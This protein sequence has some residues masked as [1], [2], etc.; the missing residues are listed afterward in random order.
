MWRPDTIMQLTLMV[1]CVRLFVVMPFVSFSRAPQGEPSVV[2]EQKQ[3]LVRELNSA[4]VA[5]NLVMGLITRTSA[6][7]LP[8]LRRPHL[9]H[10]AVLAVHR[11][12]V[13]QHL[14]APLVEAP[15]VLRGEVLEGQRELEVLQ[16]QVGLPAQELPPRVPL[17]RSLDQSLP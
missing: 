16:V 15:E 4:I 5:T 1:F 13:E 8:Q 2:Q 14:E 6:P 17:E 7:H 10:Q 12:Q 3:S 9:L 11:E